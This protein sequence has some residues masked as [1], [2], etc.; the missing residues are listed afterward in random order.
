MPKEDYLVDGKKQSL[1][2]NYD[3]KKILHQLKIGL[4]E[5][6][7]YNE[8][9]KVLMLIDIALQYQLYRQKLREYLATGENQA[10][11][12]AMKFQQVYVDG[13]K[14]LGLTPAQRKRLSLEKKK[15]EDSIFDKIDELMSEE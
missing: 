12:E 11:R 1:A 10:H 6:E 13:L 14:Q 3:G 4:Q 2:L 7:L 15:K 8:V 5:M 9:D